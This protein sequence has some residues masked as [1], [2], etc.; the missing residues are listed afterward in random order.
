M[1]RSVTRPRSEAG[2]EIDSSPVY[3]MTAATRSSGSGTSLGPSPR[4]RCPA[5]AAEI[6]GP[7]DVGDQLLDPTSTSN[8][9]WRP[10]SSVAERD[11]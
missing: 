2:R 9:P 6:P 7:G 3:G 5:F 4:S 11:G 1:A 10:R 8:D